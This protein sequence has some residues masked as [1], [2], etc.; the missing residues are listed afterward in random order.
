MVDSFVSIQVPALVALCAK[1]YDYHLL[2]PLTG[3][4]MGRDQGT[5]GT[6]I[7]RMGP[8]W[9]PTCQRL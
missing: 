6:L 8:H 3:E 2:I 5:V 1:C 9:P 4:I 7:H